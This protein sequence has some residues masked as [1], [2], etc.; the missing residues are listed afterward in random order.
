M[1]EVWPELVLVG[2]LV[3]V[4]A[5]L[6]GSEIALISLRESQLAALHDEGG[7][8]RVAADLARDPNRFLAT[9][10]VGITLAGFLASAAAAVSI[11]AVI[12]P[13]LGFLG[14]AAETTAVV[15]VTLVLSYIT[16]VL[17]ELAPKRLALQRAEAWAR[18]VGRPLHGLAVVTSPIVWLLSV[19]TD[20]VVRLF[21]GEPGSTREEVDLEELR[22][23]VMT[24]RVIR[25][26]HQE[27]LI[28]AFEFA[29]R[30]VGE[31]MTPRTKVVGVDAGT[32][33]RDAIARL[34]D[35]GHGRAPVVD[36]HGG[37]DGSIGVVSLSSLVSA[38]P[39]SLVEQHTV[40]APAFPESVPVLDALRQLQADHQQMAFVIDEFGGVS[41]I[42]TIEDL[43][44]ELV[45]EIYDESDRDVVS[46]RRLADGSIVVPGGFPIHDLVDLGID[47]PEGEY[48]TVAGLILDGLGRIGAVGDGIEVGGWAITVEAVR[49]RAVTR[50]RFRRRGPVGR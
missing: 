19:S 35:A 49:G 6:S 1:A 46:A 15:V 8:G 9:I 34:A 33:V 18:S 17:G 5:V 3:V 22:Q 20:W 48:R 14:G 23:M 2:F 41:G 36:E 4:N 13:S 24:N 40:D 42:V 28:G 30:V 27:I 38:D 45:G 32:S 25:E 47:V 31:V 11:A 44:E 39:H 26:D 29:E 37:L 16:L 50:V 12:A 21:G 43:V 10:Q 7:A